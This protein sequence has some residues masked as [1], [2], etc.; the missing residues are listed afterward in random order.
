MEKVIPED[1]LF[2]KIDKYIFHFYLLYFQIIT[3]KIKVINII[4]NIIIESYLTHDSSFVIQYE[5]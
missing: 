5:N 4:S 3:L 2:R 1:S